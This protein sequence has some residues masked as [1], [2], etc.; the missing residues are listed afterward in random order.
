MVAPARS[1]GFGGDAILEELAGQ[2]RISRLFD[3]YQR[4]ISPVARLVVRSLMAGLIVGCRG[5]DHVK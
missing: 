2:P 5:G 4:L 1:Q 3:I